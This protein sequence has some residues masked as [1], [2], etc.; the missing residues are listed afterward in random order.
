MKAILLAIVL[1]SGFL[2]VCYVAAALPALWIIQRTLLGDP[3]IL[4]SIGGADLSMVD[5]VIVA[6]LLRALYSLLVTR[7]LALD[8]PL[9][10][11][12]GVFFLVNFLATLAAGAKFGMSPM[13]RSTISLARLATEVALVPILA[14][15]ITSRAQARRCFQIVLG[16]LL[17]LAV[18]QFVNFF[19]ASR[20]FAIGE[21]QGAERG[22]LRY[23]GPVGDSVGFV[24]LLG[25]VIALC[26]ARPVPVL[27]F[28]GGIL[29]TA[30]IGAVLGL[31]VAT[32]LVVLFGID[33]DALRTVSRRWLWLAPIAALV[34]AV[35]AVPLARPMAGTLIDRLSSGAFQ[36]SGS[37]RKDSATLGLRMF[38]DNPLTGVGFMGYN[39][40]LERY[41]GKEFFS[42]AKED[43]GTANTNNQWLQVLADSGLP[44]LAAFI[45][46]VATAA[47]LFLRISRRCD[48]ALLRIGLRGAC[49]WLLAQ[50]FGNL[51]A[52][53]L[54]PSSYIAR[55][56]WVLLG[57][58]VAAGRLHADATRH[59][60]LERRLGRVPLAASR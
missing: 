18:I 10:L 45:G 59:P 25:Y 9:Y 27:L 8:R 50:T 46:V 47:T 5:G 24:L 14:Q 13:L 6:L 4:F 33:R 39:A 41:G 28:A 21:V 55:F 16:T 58:A 52:V 49:L 19:G 15:S 43:G 11:A 42:L 12:L 34:I 29:L 3:G 35:A 31:L 26:A 20:G 48:D 53:W 37:Q 40:A 22:E 36:Q 30:G 32:A 2:P 60:P 54:V 23:F 38:A 17:V 7:Q 1:L 56:L 51:A 57:I 44:G